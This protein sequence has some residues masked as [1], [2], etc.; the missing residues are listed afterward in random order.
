MAG[1]GDTSIGCTPSG[2]SAWKSGPTAPV[3]NI[4][5]PRRACLISSGRDDVAD[6][7]VALVLMPRTVLDARG[8]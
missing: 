8:R 7:S 3:V 6:G 1:Q 5:P 4:P 2:F